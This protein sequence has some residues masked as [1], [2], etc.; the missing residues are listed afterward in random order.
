MFPSILLSDFLLCLCLF[1]DGTACCQV[2]AG[3]GHFR[4]GFLTVIR[5]DIDGTDTICQYGWWE[6]RILP[7]P[8][9]WH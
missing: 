4:K 6:T 5:A 2:N 7:R 8:V 9:R 1:G 3:G